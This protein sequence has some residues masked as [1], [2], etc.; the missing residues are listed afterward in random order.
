M[1]LIVFDIS[2]FWYNIMMADCECFRIAKVAAGNE[3]IR[4]I[5]RTIYYI[6]G[7]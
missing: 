4:I 2:F 1:K 5:S 3:A 6:Q 7:G